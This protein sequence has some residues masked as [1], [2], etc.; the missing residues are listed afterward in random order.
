[1]A[2]EKTFFKGIQVPRDIKFSE[3]GSK[4][5][6]MKVS[7]PEKDM[8]QSNMQNDVAAFEAW[9]LILREE[10]KTDIE[11][12][13]NILPHWESAFNPEEMIDVNTQHFMRFLFR[14]WKFMEQFEWF[15]INK[16]DC[17]ECIERYKDRFQNTPMV[18]NIPFQTAG[19]KKKY[20]L[21]EEHILENIFTHSKDASKC[22]DI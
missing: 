19:L 22:V 13:F 4:T 6:T 1:M 8:L 11:M 12:T 2:N 14:V 16:K 20:D 21:S 10:C 7:N 5:I 9:S 3:L 15:Y 17:Y 18:N